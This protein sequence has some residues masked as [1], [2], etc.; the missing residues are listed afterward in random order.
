M[1]STLGINIFI[2][3]H[4][5]TLPNMVIKLSMHVGLHDAYPAM[6]VNLAFWREVKMTAACN[7]I[8]LGEEMRELL[9][10]N[11]KKKKRGKLLIT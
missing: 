9:D 7:F 1:I 8:S 5:D 3:Q 2:I 10:K 11:G 4:I 6:N